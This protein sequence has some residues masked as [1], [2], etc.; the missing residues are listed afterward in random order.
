MNVNS[1]MKQKHRYLTHTLSDKG[2]KGTLVNRALHPLH[3]GPFEI[4]LKFPLKVK[5]YVCLINEL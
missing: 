5:N 1:L 4:T 3:G 2:F